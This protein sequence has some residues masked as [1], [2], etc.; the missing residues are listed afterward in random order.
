MVVYAIN[1]TGKPVAFPVPLN[2]FASSY[3][4]PPV[5]AKA[6]ADAR[7]KL[8]EQIAQRQKELKAKAERSP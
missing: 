2:G 4:G 8:M 7:K 6:Y 3:A 1:V 5:D